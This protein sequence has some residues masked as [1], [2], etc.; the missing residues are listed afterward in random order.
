[1]NVA[2]DTNQYIFISFGIVII[3][4][5]I[6]NNNTDTINNKWPTNIINNKF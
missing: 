3:N 4:T 6:I 5:D 1:M 2:I